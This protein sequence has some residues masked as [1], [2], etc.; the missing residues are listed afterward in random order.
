M[1]LDHNA[2]APL[3]P[4][5]RQALLDA[6]D[7]GLGHP[8]ARHRPGRRARDLVEAARA[9]VAALAGR[10]PS[11]VTLTSGATEANVTAVHHLR[12]SG[13][14][15]LVLGA[16]EHASLRAA[17]PDAIVAP[18]GPDGRHDLDAL[19]RL[20]RDAD[21][22]LLVAAEPETGTTSDLPAIAA[23][24]AHHGVAWHCDAAQWAGRLPLDLPADTLT[25]SGHKLGA[26]TGCGALV[27]RGELRPL[28][29]GLRAEDSRAGTP[30]LLALAGLAAAIPVVTRQL[31]DGTWS[32]VA[33]RRD[34]LEAGLRGLGAVV[35]GAHRLPNTCLVSLGD[36]GLALVEALA[37]RGV[38]V[39]TG[40]ACATG[41]GPSPTLRAMGVPAALAAGAVR[42]S[43]GPSTTDDDV[44]DAL[45]AVRDALH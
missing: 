1:Y 28:L 15:R 35:H 10:P 13:A 11:H 38:C 4:E 39:G 44:R 43:L 32:R 42:F 17:A 29:P 37:L 12:A 36:D 30:D 16:T 24:V 23:L 26:P 34:A 9:A 18:V 19:D 20:L 6:L 8:A 33:A 25:V 22:L 40:S 45:A 41:T 14:R 5:A 31:H 2:T 3:L 21:A 7:A 27:H